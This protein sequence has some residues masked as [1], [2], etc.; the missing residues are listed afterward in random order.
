M[1]AALEY[2]P[3][4]QIEEDLLMIMLMYNKMRN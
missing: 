3:I 4:N 1:C 2:L